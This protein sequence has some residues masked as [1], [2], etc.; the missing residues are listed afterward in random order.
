MK[1]VLFVLL[2]ACSLLLI[3]AKSFSPGEVDGY[4]DAASATRAM[5]SYFDA[6]LIVMSSIT[7]DT[8]KADSLFGGGTLIRNVLNRTE[9]DGR[10]NIMTNKGSYFIA[11][12]IFAGQCI[13][14]PLPPASKILKSGTTVDTIIVFI[15]KIN[16]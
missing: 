2:C 11:Y 10:V 7:S 12:P 5:S 3:N 4:Q 16:Q 15:Q 6:R 13:P 1:K 9:T 8:I 14:T